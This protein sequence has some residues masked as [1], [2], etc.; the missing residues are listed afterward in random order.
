MVSGRI[1]LAHPVKDKFLSVIDEAG[2]P[3]EEGELVVRSAF[4][5][6]GYWR[7]EQESREHFR[8]DA[9]NPNQRLFHTGDIVRLVHDKGLEFRGR[10]DAQVKIKG[11]RVEL[12]E[13]EHALLNLPGVKEA[14][15][16]TKTHFGANALASF[17]VMKKGES[18]LP[19]ALRCALRLVLPQW[20]VP[21]FIYPIDELPLTLTGKIDRQLLQ[22]YT[23]SN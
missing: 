7:R 15:V 21:A 5:A 13:I 23:A 9:N 14:A 20:K 4:L 2:N 3:V 1:P 6:D 17:V 18:F 10:R 22:H 8:I 19:E 16:I 11:Y 12:L